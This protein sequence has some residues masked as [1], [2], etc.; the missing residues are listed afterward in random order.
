MK[1]V[2]GYENIQFHFNIL[3]PFHMRTRT[4]TNPAVF[5]PGNFSVWLEKVQKSS[6]R[7]Q[8]IICGSVDGQTHYCIKKDSLKPICPCCEFP[9]PD[10]VALRDHLNAIQSNVS[11]TIV[12]EK[13]NV[14]RTIVTEKAKCETVNK[15]KSAPKATAIAQRSLIEKAKCETVTKATAI[16]HRHLIAEEKKKI[17]PISKSIAHFAK[18]QKHL[19]SEIKKTTIN[20]ASTA[21]AY[22]EMEKEKSPINADADASI[23]IKKEK[24]SPEKVAPESAKPGNSEFFDLTSPISHQDSFS[25]STVYCTQHLPL[26]RSL[27]KKNQL[28]WKPPTS[29]PT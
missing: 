11:G 19:L 15:A 29:V 23:L 26:S 17:S 7:F 27:M 22:N 20:D 10:M 18:L 12:T 13:T 9:F 21:V 25:L 1:Y 6:F 2:K 4:G 14:S 28:S 3:S 8:D 16:A 24:D 5:D